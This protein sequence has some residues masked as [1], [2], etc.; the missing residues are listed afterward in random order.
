MATWI[1]D[2]DVT[3]G[4]APFADTLFVGEA[5][6]RDAREAPMVVVEDALETLESDELSGESGGIGPSMSFP[7]LAGTRV[8]EFFSPLALRVKRFRTAVA[9]LLL[10]KWLGDVKIT[11]SRLAAPITLAFAPGCRRKEMTTLSPTF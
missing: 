7:A 6:G 1:G 10:D 5:E 3:P 8:A 2:A 11:S 4:A 9:L